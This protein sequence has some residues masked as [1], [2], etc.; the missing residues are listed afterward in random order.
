GDLLDRPRILGLDRHLH[1]HRLED[2]DGVA[3]VDLIAD[4]NLDLPHGAGDVRL[5][6]HGRERVG[7]GHVRATAGENIRPCVPNGTAIR[8]WSSRRTTRPTESAPPSTPSAGRSPAPTSWSPTT[9]PRTAPRIWRWPEAPR[10]SAGAGRTARGQTSL[11]PRR[12]RWT[13]RTPPR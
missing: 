6:V 10:W 7:W 12:P 1:L 11:P 13:G 9:R 8:W 2:D 5:D 4:P 3:L